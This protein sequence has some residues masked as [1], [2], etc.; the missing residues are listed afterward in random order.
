MALVEI[1]AA[2]ETRQVLGEDLFAEEIRAAFDQRGGVPSPGNH[3]HDN[4]AADETHSA[5]HVPAP[6]DHD[7]ITNATERRQDQSDGTLGQHGQRERDVEQHPPA[8]QSLGHQEKFEERQLHE[9]GQRHIHAR[10]GGGLQVLEGGRHYHRGD[11]RR[12]VVE[13]PAQVKI[14]GEQAGDC[15]RGG[16]QAHRKFIYAA[17]DNRNDRGHPMHQQRLG[18]NLD[19][20]AHRQD[21]AAAVHDVEDGYRF[22]RL[23]LGIEWIAAEINQIER[24]SDNQQYRP[25]VA[26]RG[27]FLEP[28][29]TTGDWCDHGSRSG[30]IERRLTLGDGSRLGIVAGNLF[31]EFQLSNVLTLQLELTGV[32]IATGS[33]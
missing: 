21:H 31:R 4:R 1:G 22:A 10:A 13:Q 33:E 15:E 32:R 25:C 23:A 5:Q 17:D 27:Y 30:G 14:T 18:W 3:Q 6:L 12:H 9:E 29:R 7:P 26:R 28:I 11:K 24:D 16:G 20:G 8:G 19:S 2:G